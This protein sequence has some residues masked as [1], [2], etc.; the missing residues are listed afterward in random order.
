MPDPEPPVVSWAFIADAMLGRLARWLRLLGFDTLYDP[1]GEDRGLARQS[2]A[3]GR[4]LL[5]R[6]RGL[7]ERRIVTRGLLILHDRPADQLR[8]VLDSFSL[9]PSAWKIFSRCTVCNGELLPREPGEVEGQVP[10]FIHRRHD[11][12]WLC[13]G[14]FRIYWEGSHRVRA[15]EV[16]RRW[17]IDPSQ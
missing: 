6:D 15:L 7:L 14:C 1:F 13:P 10:P 17:G 16:L 9:R 2:A 12:F 11:R 5:T 4:I 8:Q 3:L